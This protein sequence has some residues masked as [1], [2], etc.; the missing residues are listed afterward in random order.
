MGEIITRQ[1]GERTFELAPSTRRY[2]S[3]GVMVDV[4][5]T[6]GGRRRELTYGIDPAPVGALTDEVLLALAEPRRQDLV[7]V[8]RNFR[9][10]AGCDYQYENTY[11]LLFSTEPVGPYVVISGDETYH[12]ITDEPDLES[13]RRAV[14]EIVE[15]QVSNQYPRYPEEI[16][17]LDTGRSIPFRYELVVT[18]G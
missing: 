4:A 7:A 12:W 9:I 3:R 18:L 11:G 16:R 13:A 8:M 17:E 1:I 5:E 15:D 6:T 14:A 10:V 2:A